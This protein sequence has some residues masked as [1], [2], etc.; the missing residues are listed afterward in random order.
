MEMTTE[1]LKI[2]K[3]SVDRDKNFYIE[4]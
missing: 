4:E 3:E 1:R 2:K